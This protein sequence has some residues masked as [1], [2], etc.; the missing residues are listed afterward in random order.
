MTGAALLA[1]VAGSLLPADAAAP[2][3]PAH[4]L[5][6]RLHDLP[7]GY[8]ANLASSETGPLDECDYLHPADAEPELAAFIAQYAPKGC[9]AVYLRL[10]RVPGFT[11]APIAVG[12]A[13][14][15][16]GGVGAAEAGL[17]VAPEAIGHLTGDMALEEVAPAATIGEADRLFHWG[18]GG[19]AFASGHT[20]DSFLAWCSGGV[21]GVVFVEARSF[22]ASDGAATELARRQQ[23]RIEHPTPYTRAEQDSSEVPLDNPALKIRAYW[24]G[25][26]FEPG[27]AAPPAHLRGSFAID[28]QGVARRQTLWLAYSK[29]MV[30]QEWT[31]AGWKRFSSAHPNAQFTA[32]TRIGDTVVAVDLHRCGARCGGGNRPYG[33]LQA[34]KRVIRGLRF[35]PQHRVYRSP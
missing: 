12:T 19:H 13:A 14:M 26:T 16:A 23:D 1:L 11:P 20:A 3:A 29:G 18:E 4:R 15:D 10:Y 25:R 28:G 30:L 6:L 27:G 24:L 8:L 22:A 34:A 5:L 17:A 7:P 31:R 2:G 35:R 9:F 32:V 33:S 21:V